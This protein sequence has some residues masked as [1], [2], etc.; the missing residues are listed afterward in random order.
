VLALPVTGVLRDRESETYLVEGGH[1]CRCQTAIVVTVWSDSS[2]V[3]SK[4]KD[5]TWTRRS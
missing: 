1:V 2:R 5:V 4:T 3:T